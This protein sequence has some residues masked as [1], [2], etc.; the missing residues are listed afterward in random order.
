MDSLKLLSDYSDHVI[1]GGE[2]M[3]IAISTNKGGVL[4]T[5][6]TVNI[7][8]VMSRHK[9]RVLII[10]TDNQG[11]CLLS[12][13]KNP[14][15]VE[16]TLYD[17]LVSGYDPY[18]AIVKVDD[19]IDILPANDDMTFF[20]LD[21]LS[22]PKKY[23]HPFALMKNSLDPIKNDYDYILID[24]PPNLGLV[25]ANVLTFADQVLIPFQ[26]ESYS[27]RSLVKIVKAIEDFR[28]HNQNL[29]ILGVLTTLIDMR[30]VLH[31]QVLQECRKFC[32]EK[33]I[34]VFETYIPKSVRYAASVAY[35]GKPIT[36]ADPKNPAAE[37]Y[38]R[39]WEEVEK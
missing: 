6:I 26:P 21:V 28:Q 7:A 34:R 4:K 12:F 5:S 18:S 30:T 19:Y 33:G 22:N 1:N 23:S 10:D 37:Y 2:I 16:K 38:F 8:G 25:Q 24:T 13:G 31:S 39:L 17:V 15:K 27:M 35:E 20:D 11:N 36:V 29:S 32:Y 14:D 3:K 9:K